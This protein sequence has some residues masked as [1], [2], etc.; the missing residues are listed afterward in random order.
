LNVS[1]EALE[2]HVIVRPVTFMSVTAVA[3]WEGKQ[4]IVASAKLYRPEAE[5]L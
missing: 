5:H 4:D 1:P 2:C 3:V